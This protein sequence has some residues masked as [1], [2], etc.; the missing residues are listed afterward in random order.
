MIRKLRDIS[1]QRKQASLLGLALLLGV[2][3][4]SA[5]AG[6]DEPQ[7]KK[8]REPTL[9]TSGARP[10]APVGAKPAEKGVTKPTAGIAKDHSADEEAI[11]STGDTF[12]KAYG[13]ADVKAIAAHFTQDA[14]FIDE[15]GN[16]HQGRQAIETVMAACFAENPGQ[17]IA[18]NIDSIRFISPG[19][20]V[21]DG[22]TTMTPQDGEQVDSRYTAVHVK[23]NGKWLAASVR[24]HAP[25]DR[26]QHRAR[27]QQ[28]AWLQ[29]DW[30]DESGD[31]VVIF[32]CTAVDGGNF[33]LRKFTIQIAGQEA[34]SGTQRIGWDPLI[35]KLRT[36]V[37]DSEGGHSEGLW[38]RDGDR[39]VLKSTGVTADGQ[40]AS[41]TCIYT[42]VNEH[43]MTW[44]SV[45]HE[46]SGVQ[47][48]D[49]EIVTIVR[50]APVPIPV[51]ISPL[52]K[53]D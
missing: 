50:R 18:L 33:L 10:A 27:L 15:Q 1:V 38:H 29:G 52:T 37:F 13:D 43:T 39:W 24:E 14:E 2:I 5:A 20:A 16:I 23:T 36:W 6:K 21:E 46:I 19:V 4:F 49:S 51:E 28:L 11:R 3:G 30:V 17:Q 45:D 26:R 40:A 42:F 25:A 12:M 8:G 35:G 48:P 32:S 22:T 53:S 47:L 41:G 34:M 31:S 44:Q 9:E 7:V